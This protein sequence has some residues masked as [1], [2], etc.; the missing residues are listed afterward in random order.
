[1]LYAFADTNIFVRIITQGRPGCEHSLFEDLTTL[2]EGGVVRLLVPEVV[3]LELE[4]QVRLLPK[5]FESECDKLITSLTKAT[6][7]VWN[8]IDALK[9]DLLQQISNHKKKLD[10]WKEAASQI[11]RFLRSTS[12]QTIPLTNEI[13]LNTRAVSSPADCR[14][15]R[16]HRTRTHARRVP[17]RLLSGGPR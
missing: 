14:D 12:V 4:K 6:E 3:V 7:N 16:V 2:V 1:M 11:M 15:P 8:E 17:C 5:Q 9:I 10:E 13:R